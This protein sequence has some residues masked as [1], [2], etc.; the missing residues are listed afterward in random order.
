MTVEQDRLVEQRLVDQASGG[1]AA[2]FEQLYRSHVGRVYALCLRMTGNAVRAEESTQDAFVR[3]WEK[4]DTFRGDSTFATWLFR[5]AVNGIL[6]GRRA[7]QRRTSRVSSVENLESLPS[8][9]IQG[10]KHGG[11]H[12]WARLDIEEAIAQLPDGARTVFVL[13]DVEGYKHREIAE[14]LGTTTGSTKAQ[15]HRARNLLREAL[16]R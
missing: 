6:T 16:E 11:A 3:A 8:R 5:V 12:V 4:L 10:T 15:L 2:A 1:D 9:A 14:L 7:H 13:A